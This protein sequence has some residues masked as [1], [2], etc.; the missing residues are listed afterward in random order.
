M[1][2]KPEEQ[3]PVYS[4]EVQDIVGKMSIRFGIWVTALI[5][6]IAAALLFFGFVLRYPDVVSGSITVNSLNPPV[7]LVAETNGKISFNVEPKQNVTEGQYLA[8]IDNSTPTETVRGIDSLLNI[9]RVPLSNLNWPIDSLD[10]F[11]N[12]FPRS[13]MLGELTGEYLAFTSS[14][15]K[16]VYFKKNNIYGIQ[17]D[18][19]ITKRYNLQKL[20]EHT[21]E[22]IVLKEGQ[23]DLARKFYHKDSI[24]FHGKFSFENELDI[25]YDNYLKSQESLISIK[26]ESESNTRAIIEVTDQLN[27]INIQSIETENEL[28]SLLL[29]S[30]EKLLSVIRLWE[31]RYVIKAPVSGSV[32]FLKFWQDNFF[33][34]AGEPVLSVIPVETSYYGEV[35][36][37]SAGAGKVSIGQR[38]VIKLDNYPYLEYGAVTGHVASM[39]L[40]TGTM[41]LPNNNEINTYLVNVAL[42]NGLTTNFDSELAF[43]HEMKGT[44]EI[45]TK[46]RRLIQRLF[47]N[48]KYR[49]K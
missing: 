8:I 36:L 15:E 25:A 2:Q 28:K 30:Y 10:Y 45:I 38:V 6:F 37:P 13:I 40:V 27:Q 33:V 11:L 7:R 17:K 43:K 31:K 44:A 26:K 42:D 19:L 16:W 34:Q 21:G 23:L 20:S 18:A 48:L 5:L 24:L 29:T 9:M 12:N 47:D 35:L 32:D 41:K 4:E 14:L 49:I 46:E 22:Q 3:I 1:E 39:S